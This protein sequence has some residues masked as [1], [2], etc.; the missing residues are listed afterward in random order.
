MHIKISALTLFGPNEVNTSMLRTGFE[1]RGLDP[2][3]AIDEL[4]KSV[5]LG[6]IAEPE[7][8]ANVI[9]FFNF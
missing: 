8:I 4:N 9:A 5:P 3:A 6:H 7:E 2:D 1:I